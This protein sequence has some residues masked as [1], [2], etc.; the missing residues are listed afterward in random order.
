MIFYTHFYDVAEKAPPERDDLQ[1]ERSNRLESF[2]P[3]TIATYCF[4]RFD[5]ENDQKS[6]S[7]KENEVWQP[8]APTY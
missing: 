8:V 5:N 1:S 2:F 3:G 7:R 6:C 4:L